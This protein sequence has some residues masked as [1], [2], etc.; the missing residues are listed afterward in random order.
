[1]VHETKTEAQLTPR[2]SS[3]LLLL[4]LPL[5][6]QPCFKS[7]ETYFVFF[8]TQSVLQ[9]ILRSQLSDH[10]NLEDKNVTTCQLTVADQGQKYFR[11][12]RSTAFKF[13]ATV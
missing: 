5:N 10:M 12:Q 4:I 2:N 3:H 9:L 13:E 7:D 8:S 6:V 11:A 1:M